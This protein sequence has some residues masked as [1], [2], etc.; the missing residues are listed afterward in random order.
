M[1][2]LSR[3]RRPSG[4]R[5][6]FRADAGAIKTPEKPMG[7]V[8]PAPAF[9]RTCAHTRNQAHDTRAAAKGAQA[10]A[11]ARARGT[12]GE[13]SRCRQASGGAEGTKWE[14]KGETYAQDAR[15]EDAGGIPQARNEGFMRERTIVYAP[16][17]LIPRCAMQDSCWG[18][19]VVLPSRLAG[20]LGEGL[21]ASRAP[22]PGFALPPPLARKRPPPASPASGRGVCRRQSA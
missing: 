2:I 19:Y 17:A 16:R 9:A 8:R 12:R 22:L 7:G 21:S 5:L 20:G 14:Q 10:G 4:G 6:V 15:T 11:T 18:R 13:G 1:A 3:S